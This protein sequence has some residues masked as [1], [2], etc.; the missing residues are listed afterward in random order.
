MFS[1]ASLTKHLQESSVVKSQSLVTMEWNLNDATNIKQIGNYRYRPL[2][3]GSTFQT[4]VPVYDATDAAKA[5]TGATD[6]DILVDGGYDEDNTPITF[7]SIKEKNSLYFSLED[8]FGKFRPR[9]GI[10]KFIFFDNKKIPETSPYMFQRPRYYFAD[11]EDNFKYWTSYRTENNVDRGLSSVSKRS[12]QPGYDITDTAP[13]IVYKTSVYS[14][15]IVIKM[16]TN[17]GTILS[18]TAA[19][20]PFYG[21]T[22]K[23]VPVVWKLQKLSGTSWED[24]VT[25]ANMPSSIPAD[26]Y[27]EFSY[28]LQVPDIYKDIFVYAGEVSSISALPEKAYNGYT[29]LVKTSSTSRGEM[30]IWLEVDGLGS[31]TVF[32]PNY[33]WAVGSQEIS[34]TTNFVTDFSK[35]D[36]FALGAKTIY[37]Q[38]DAIDGLRLVV[39]QMNTAQ[40]SFDLIEMSPKI[41]A[42]VSDRVSSHSVTK[43]ASDISGAG[44]PVGKMM[45]AT[46][47]LEIFDY[48]QSFSMLNTNSILYNVPNKNMQVKT[49]EAIF[50]VPDIANSLIK[51]N[52]YVPIKTMYVEDSPKVNPYD[53]KISFSLRDLNILFETT[54]APQIMLTNKT[55]GYIICVLLDSIGF[56][57]YVFY[58]TATEHDQVI[59]YFFIGPDTSVS[60][61]LEQLA[62]S[63]Q[64]AMF[65]DESNNFVT[66]SKNYLMPTEAE[67]ETN[68]E[69]SA[70]QNIIN[71]ASSDNIVYNSGK[72]TYVSRYI[73]KSYGTI[74]QSSLDLKE[75]TW[76]YKPVMLWE[77]SPSDIS[78]PTNEEGG[79][80]AS[81]SL[82]AIP[83]N[84]DLSNALPQVSG[85]KIINNIMD[86]GEGINWISRYSGY[87]Y[88]NGEVLKY[89]AV[90]YFVSGQP[91][92]VWIR[93]VQEFKDYFAKL[94]F[95]GKIYPT[96][97][98]RIYSEPY[99]NS[100]GT[101][102]TGAVAKHG[103][104]QF[105]TPVVTHPAGVSSYWSN[106]ENMRGCFMKSDNIFDGIQE[107]TATGAAGIESIKYK[108]TA[109]TGIMKNFLSASNVSESETNALKKATISG[110]MQ[111]SALIM[112]GPQFASTQKPTDFL[113]YV[114][115]PMTNKFVHFGTRVRIVGSIG[116]GSQYD[117]RGVGTSV[118]YT[119]SGQPYEKVLTNSDGSTYK[120]TVTPKEGTT[121]GSGG[122]I[123][124]LLNPATNVGYYFEISALTN[125]NVNNYDGAEPINNVFF[126]KLQ[127]SAGASTDKDAAVPVMLWS[128]L[129]PILVDDGKFTGQS[130]MYAEKNPTVYD[131]SVEYKDNV[132]SRTFYLY[133]NNRLIATVEDKAPLPHVNDN[134]VALFVRGSSRLMFENIYAL[135]TNYSQDT[136]SLINA[137]AAS[138]VF[139]AGQVSVTDAFRKYAMS[140]MVSSMYLSGIDPTQPPQYNLYFDEF[141]T[142]MREAAYFNIRYDKAYP[143]LTAKL[144]PTFNNLK[145]Y[146][147][148][149][150]NQGPYGAEFLIFNNTDTVLTLDE[151][152]GNYLRIQGVT[153]TQQSQHELTVDDYF[154]RSSD[155]SSYKFDP[156]IVSQANKDYNDIKTSRMTYGK[157]E[158]TLDAPYVQ[159]EDAAN[160][161]MDWI[162]KKVMKPR[163]S[164]GIDIFGMPVIQLGDIVKVSYNRNGVDELPDA[165]FVVYNIN[166]SR[167]TSGPKT[168]IYLSEV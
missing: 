24:I 27:V 94:T 160:N 81:Y 9:S 5:Y 29:Y 48:D 133:I 131:L 142:I 134:N 19:I 112:N 119:S 115:K 107:A 117:Q 158:F 36:S 88:A 21:D 25:T 93:N 77:V 75:K 113:S 26:G 110:T 86:F 92:P 114:Y 162:I 126:Y 166:Y 139:G 130:R 129:G 43:Q 159:S 33:A 104:G 116:N 144:S 1:D 56:S 102:K 125:N 103:R 58:R 4:L 52:Y 14:N 168:T 15:K 64:T 79:S 106:P 167:D 124:V 128:G 8:C 163:K 38:F 68:L 69:I 143:A 60:Q 66:M 120:V 30:H 10:N 132:G 105:G 23:T 62:V 91:A 16:Q 78:N 165:R 80:A 96:G 42:D 109:V 85:G 95:N 32:S 54:I 55:L 40:S 65:F 22:N 121:G 37:R 6:A 47:A 99:F 136:G 59:P 2:E 89:D 67:R 152:S 13:F 31:W 51:Y 35:N 72:I 70:D 44:L 84:T 123:A 34:P 17:V 140:G 90:E 45:A 82:S 3:T 122:G 73:Q 39:E 74:A 76:I 12:D 83:L 63:T 98:V 154:S 148:S 155:F 149:G 71:I 146:T 108:E 151:S 28:G 61:V 150:F 100:D 135:S 57:N 46:G 50:D 20:D 41:F 111:S 87:F 53:R 145:G 147:V 7:K 101:Y 11:K 156:S 141:G 49:Y 161:M 18:P 138:S 153:F 137:P 157:K 164:V 97:R 118:Y 127:R